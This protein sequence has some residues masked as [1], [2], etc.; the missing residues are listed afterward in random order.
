MDPEELNKILLHAVT[1]GWGKQSYLQGWD[2]EGKSYNYTCKMS[3]CIEVAEQVYKGGTTYKTTNI[4][5]DAN[6]NI[7]DRK[8]KV[9]KSNFPNIPYKSRADK[10][11]KNYSRHLSNEPTSEKKWF[12]HGLG[13]STEE[14]KLLKEYSRK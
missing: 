12:V 6:H 14:C 13:H 8:I 2:F 5:S 1:N 11:K 3:E 7:H 4:R 10:Q 9:I